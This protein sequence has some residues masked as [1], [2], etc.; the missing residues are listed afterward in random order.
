MNKEQA[1]ERLNMHAFVHEDLE[2]EKVRDGFLGMLRP[3]Q[4]RLIDE[5][6]H[7]LMEILDV[8]AEEL[9][10]D[11]LD[12]EIVSRLWSICQYARAWAI[13]PNGM[14]RRNELISDEELG[15]MAEWIDMLSYAVATLLEGGGREEAFW[16]YK[17]YLN[18]QE[19][20]RKKNQS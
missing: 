12:R 17:E 10:K 11:P 6:F 18:E 20:I 13:E 5:N 1:V 4:G 9:E 14:L 15:K 16:G 3:Y 19:R 8:L 7:E 2:H